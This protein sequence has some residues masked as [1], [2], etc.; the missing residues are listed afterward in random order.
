M[1]RLSIGVFPRPA[2]GRPRIHQKSCFRYEIL[3]PDIVRLTACLPESANLTE[4]AACRRHFAGRL[5]DVPMA[6]LPRPADLFGHAHLRAGKLAHSSEPACAQD[7][8]DLQ[9]R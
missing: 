1:K 2:G 9:W 5:N 7:A 8:R 4:F 3:P 6:H